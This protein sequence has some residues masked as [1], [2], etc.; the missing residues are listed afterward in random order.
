MTEEAKKKI[1]KL[2]LDIIKK[3]FLIVIGII[4]VLVLVLDILVWKVGQGAANQA[5]AIRDKKVQMESATE[6]IAKFAGE[7]S[8]LKTEEFERKIPF[9]ALPPVA[10]MQQAGLIISEVGAQGTLIISE[11][12]DGSSGSGASSGTADEDIVAVGSKSLKEVE[13]SFVFEANYQDLM[14]IIEK[15]ATAEPLIV[16]K[17]FNIAR[18]DSDPGEGEEVSGTPFVVMPEPEGDIRNLDVEL[19]LSTFTEVTPGEGV[20]TIGE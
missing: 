14:K 18:A 2:N 12:D 4:L 15:L 16:I 9:M 5:K 13:F 17:G 6:K 20:W 1:P 11:E 8:Y 19:K 3:N 7:K 10:A